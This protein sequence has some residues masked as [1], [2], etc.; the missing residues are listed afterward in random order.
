MAT[1]FEIDCA[2][3]LKENDSNRI[4][5]NDKAANDIQFAIQFERKA[6]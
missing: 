3:M 4:I 5:V 2:I 6:A 1:Q